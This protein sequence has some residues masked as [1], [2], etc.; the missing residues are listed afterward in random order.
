ML[1]RL[2]EQREALYQ[3]AFE[4]R[5]FE[6]TLTN[7]EWGLIEELISL[8][9]PI[10]EAS[11]MLIKEPLSA[12][13]PIA[14]TLHGKLYT[15]K[16]INKD[17]DVVRCSLVNE[18]EKYF[19]AL[20]ERRVHCLSTFLDLRFKDKFLLEGRNIFLAKIS[21][22][23]KEELGDFILPFDSENDE[24]VLAPSPK[25]QKLS[26]FDD[27]NDIASTSN[28]ENAGPSQNSSD[29][30]DELN[31]YLASGCA[32]SREDPLTAW[33]Q[34]APKFPI[35]S[36]IA[37]KFLT[38]PAT[39]VPSEATFKV[40]RDVYDYRRYID[41]SVIEFLRSNQHI[42]DK[43]TEL[44]FEIPDHSKDKFSLRIEYNDPATI[45][46]LRANQQQ[47]FG[48]CINVELNAF[49]IPDTDGVDLHLGWLPAS[50]IWEVLAREVW[51]TFAPNIQYLNFRDGDDLE[52]LRRETSPTIL[53]DCNQLNFIQSERMFPDD[54]ICDDGPNA[55]ACQA[56]AKWLHTPRKDGQLRRLLCGNLYLSATDGWLNS[57]KEAFLCAITS[58]SY[59]I[60]FNSVPMLQILFD[61]PPPPPIEPFE[62]LNERTKEKLTLEQERGNPFAYDD[63]WLLKR[64]PINGGTADKIPTDLNQVTFHLSGYEP[65]GPLSPEEEA[66]QSD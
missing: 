10:E 11:K 53:T 21:S 31:K 66:D 7:D 30:D 49:H 47:I 8:L 36:K 58:A 65:I 37:R 15:A 28:K 17:I 40:A 51:P 45:A 60:D 54:T 22:W 12:Q 32:N 55:T 13:I 48:T 20:R 62:L 19:F 1:S 6:M 41:Y 39:S 2:F 26:L 9:Q 46:F 42:W 4:N 43:G 63:Y 5:N 35:L 44:T 64:C 59:Q 25:K 14:L 23:L 33:R 38:A 24:I 18:L 34:M 50:V 27:L 61:R 3:Y 29:I 57:V 52:N 56:L 16:L